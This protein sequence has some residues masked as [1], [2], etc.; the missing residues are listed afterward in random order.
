MPQR[1]PFSRRPT[2]IPSAGAYVSAVTPGTPAEAAGLKAGDVIVAVNNEK[3][4]LAMDLA[5]IVQKYKPG[6]KVTLTISRDG[7]EQ[8]LQVVLGQHPDN[9]ERPYL[10]VSYSSM[11]P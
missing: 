6:D 2:Q 9:A 5:Q 1:T 3:I 10:G 4:S 8:S 11:T 7:A